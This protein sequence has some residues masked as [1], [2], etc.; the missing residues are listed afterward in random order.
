MTF[1]ISSLG[2]EAFSGS[3]GFAA[4]GPIKEYP[5]RKVLAEVLKSMLSSG[6]S[7]QDVVGGERLSSGAADKLAAALRH[8][9]NFVTRMRHLEIRSARLGQLNYEG[10]M[11]EQHDVMLALWSGQTTNCVRETDL[12]TLAAAHGDDRDNT[13]QCEPQ[14]N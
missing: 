13:L 7:K 14:P 12:Q 10:A 2:S 8:N 9:V 11:F 5:D 1:S 3:I 4:F 6:R